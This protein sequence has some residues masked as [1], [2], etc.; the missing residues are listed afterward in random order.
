[1]PSTDRPTC[2]YIVTAS[3][4]GFAPIYYSVSSRGLGQGNTTTVVL[5]IVYDTAA[6]CEVH[7]HTPLFAPPYLSEA[8]TGTDTTRRASLSLNPEKKIARKTTTSTAGWARNGGGPTH[9]APPPP[10]MERQQPT[11]PS[12]PPPPPPHQCPLCPRRVALINRTFHPGDADVTK[13]RGED[14]QERDV[15]RVWARE[16]PL[17]PTWHPFPPVVLLRLPLPLLCPCRAR[18]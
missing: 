14:K 17:N 7:R 10:E 13:R 4:L 15:R 2:K 16:D 6:R 12:L 8:T 1:M 3:H 5:I 11:L 9:L 18:L